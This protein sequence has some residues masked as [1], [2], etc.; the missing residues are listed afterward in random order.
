MTTVFINGLGLIGATLAQLMKK[1]QPDLTIWAADQQRENLTAMLAQ[2]TIDQAVSFEKGAPAADWILLAGP[3]QV[4]I[5]NLAQ[6]ATMPLK[7]K[8]VVTD[9]GSNKEAILQAAGPLMARGIAFIGGHPMAGSHLSGSRNANPAFLMQHS[10]FLINGSASHDQLAAFQQLLAAGQFRFQALTAAQ[11]DQLVAA[12][13][14]LPHFLAF[15]LINTI[16]PELAAWQIDPGLPSGG[17]LDT[18][19]VAK[20]DPTMWTAIFMTEKDT[21][22]DQLTAFQQR[23]T[24]LAQAVA[25]GEAQQIRAFLQAAQAGRLSLEE[26]T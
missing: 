23:L 18:T 13:S 24:D 26:R 12:T 9:V 7:E 14:H 4:I 1:G 25:D 22:L 5:E 10:Y 21:L 16:L 11:H 19:R 20:A 2:G 6:L 15:A 17:L 3:V 8:V